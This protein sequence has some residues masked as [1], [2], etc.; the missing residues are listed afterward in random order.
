MSFEIQSKLENSSEEIE[1]QRIE[2][3]Q[4]KMDLNRI[5][6]EKEMRIAELLKKF[7]IDGDVMTSKNE[8]NDLKD[9]EN[10]EGGLIDVKQQLVLATHIVKVSEMHFMQK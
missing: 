10:T 2:G 8:G 6:E 7:S 1:R 3:E 9:L 4:S 5:I